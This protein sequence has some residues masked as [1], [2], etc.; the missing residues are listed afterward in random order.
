M[1]KILHL[2]SSMRGERSASSTVAKS[3]L[4]EFLRTNA[5]YSV[6][7][8]N[9]WQ[10]RMP[11]FDGFMQE[12]KY[13]LLNGKEHTI[14]HKEAWGKIE[15]IVD[16]F[17][18]ADKYVISLPMWNFGMPYILK[19]YLD[20]LIQPGLTFTFSPETGYAGLVT[21]KPVLIVAARSGSYE[22]AAASYDH[23][24]P[25]LKQ[26]LQFIGFT[27]IRTVLVDNTIGM[28]KNAWE[29][30]VE[31]AKKVALEIAPDF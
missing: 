15:Q 30:A 2:E 1:P 6:D 22:G 25:F 17:K 27:D 18:S 19:H 4:R 23:Q 9:L 3:F 5:D 31:R 7:T 10:E 13:V 12:A 14:E 26:L 24:V 21:G 29:L 20:L 11:E 16:R 28:E 8:L